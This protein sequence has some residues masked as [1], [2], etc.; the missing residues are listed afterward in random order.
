MIKKDSWEIHFD[1]NSDSTRQKAGPSRLRERVRRQ[2]DLNLTMSKS[3]KDESFSGR[4]AIAAS[5]FLPA[6]TTHS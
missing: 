2:A 5:V 1:E 3:G 4:P 6:G